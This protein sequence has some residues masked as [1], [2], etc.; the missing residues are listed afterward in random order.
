MRTWF[1]RN[2]ARIEAKGYALV[3]PFPDSPYPGMFSNPEREKYVV[4]AN[5]P[6][7]G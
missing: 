2:A 5:A 3:T 1:V 6:W 7:L 4:R